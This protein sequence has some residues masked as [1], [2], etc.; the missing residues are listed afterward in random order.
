MTMQ[1]LWKIALAW[2]TFSALCLLVI[3]LVSTTAAGVDCGTLFGGQPL[4][5]NGD[6]TACAD[7]RSL[8][9]LPAVIA[10]ISAGLGLLVAFFAYAEATAPA[11]TST[12]S[13]VA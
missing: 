7:Q 8:L 3:G 2:A 13:Q 10:A 5:L 4:T 1:L 11:K 9:K 6:L 12:V